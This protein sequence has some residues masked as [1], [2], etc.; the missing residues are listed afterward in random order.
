MA[1]TIKSISELKRVFQNRATYAAKMTRD[2]MFKVFQKHINEYYHE[3][4][5]EG[6]SIPEQYDRLYKM[7]NSLIKT[8]VV[9]SEY[10]ISCKVE[11]DRDYLNY[12]YPGGATGR[13][14]WEWANDKTHGGTIQGKLRVW[15][16]SIEELGGRDGIIRLMKQNLK[17]Q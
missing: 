17:K 10:E 13:E 12:T 11:I 2:E 16:D 5:F 9:Q 15:N 1:Q 3:P 7:L 14:V 4:V 8:D 6:S